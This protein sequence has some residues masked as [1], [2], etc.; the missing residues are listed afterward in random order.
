MPRGGD[1][2]MATRSKPG[3]NSRPDEAGR[4]DN[5]N[6]HGLIARSLATVLARL[7]VATNSREMSHVPS[8]VFVPA[9]A[10]PC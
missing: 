6:F 4:A 7:G 9:A 5:E 1:N 3:D 8:S 2:F 10:H